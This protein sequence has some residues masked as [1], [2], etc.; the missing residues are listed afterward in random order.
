METENRP[1]E[2][3]SVCSTDGK[4]QPVRFRF[5]DSERTVQTAH[6]QEIV[7]IKEIS[8][9]GIEA[10]VYVCKARLGEL[11]RLLEIKYFVRT[12]RWVLFRVIY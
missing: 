4:M 12:H 6:I 5:E 1:V 9:V 8:Y 7:C 2:M 10:L 11:E 3:I